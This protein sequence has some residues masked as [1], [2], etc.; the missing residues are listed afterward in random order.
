M[1]GISASAKAEDV[2]AYIESNFI[3]IESKRIV[4]KER[5]DNE[6]KFKMKPRKKTIC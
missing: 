1:L 6:I 2:A 5:G 3:Y 4:S